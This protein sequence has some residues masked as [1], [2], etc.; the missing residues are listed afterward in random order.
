M[1]GAPPC[2][3]SPNGWI[4]RLT[5]LVH[6]VCRMILQTTEG[7]SFRISV[8]KLTGVLY[9]FSS[10]PFSFFPPVRAEFFF[11]GGRGWG[12]MEL[13]TETANSLDPES[14]VLVMV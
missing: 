11:V 6:R 10:F 5:Q 14:M 8:I 1:T 2:E 13:G 9:I 4:D 7:I 12:A 3:A